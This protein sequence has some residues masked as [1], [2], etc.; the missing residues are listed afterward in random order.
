MKSFIVTYLALLILF[1]GIFANTNTLFE[2]SELI[3]DYQLHSVK[4][5]DDAM[6][7][8]SKHFG[9]L[10]EDHKKQHQQDRKGHKRPAQN[11]IGGSHVDFTLQASYFTINNEIEIDLLDSNFHYLD[12]FSTFE[13]QPVFQPPQL[14]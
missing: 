12:L 1:Q 9:D 10:K 5:G 6:S 11:K 8:L 14:A 4:Y 2:I 7:F 13:K 3:E